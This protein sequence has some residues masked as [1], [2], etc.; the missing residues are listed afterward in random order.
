MMYQWGQLP[1]FEQKQSMTGT[2]L[3][4][5]YLLGVLLS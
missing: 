5:M 2:S 3:K 4:V 1:G